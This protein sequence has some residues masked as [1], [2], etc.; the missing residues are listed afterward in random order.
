[1]SA[2]ANSSILGISVTSAKTSSGITAESGTSPPKTSSKLGAIAASAGVSA[3]VS[4][5][6][7]NSSNSGKAKLS[8]S[9]SAPKTSSREAAMGSANS[10]SSALMLVA[11]S[12]S[13]TTDKTSGITSSSSSSSPQNRS[14]IVDI[15]GAS[16]SVTR[17]TFSSTT[18][19]AINCSEGL[20]PIWRSPFCRT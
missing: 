4:R 7:G 13:G 20:P 17:G 11:S 10:V 14:L 2:K 16:A 9:I 5:T 19:K 12:V 3:T 8:R 15:F 1:M 6:V 18:V